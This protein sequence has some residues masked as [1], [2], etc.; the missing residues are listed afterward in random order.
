LQV[1]SSAHHRV[2]SNPPPPAI[3]ESA[4]AAAAAAGDDDID[5]LCQVRLLFYATVP[6]CCWRAWCPLV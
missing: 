5:S 3:A 6:E 4:A 1:Y 2:D